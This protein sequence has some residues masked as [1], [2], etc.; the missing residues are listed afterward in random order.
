MEIVNIRDN[1]YKYRKIVSLFFVLITIILLFCMVKNI[2]RSGNLEVIY[3]D[4][5]QGD[6]ILIKD[7]RGLNFLID[8]GSGHITT[9]KVQKE[10]SVFNKALDSVLITHPDSD[11]SGGVVSVINSIDTERVIISTENDYSNYI[12]DKDSKVSFVNTF[13]NISLSNEISLK[14]LNPELGILGTENGKSIVNTMSYGNFNFIFTGDADSET[15]RKLVS[16]GYFDK[17]ENKTSV[18][19]LK[20][21]HHGS[22]TSSSEIFLKKIKPEYCILSVG[23]NNKYGHPAKNAMDRLEKYCKNIYRTDLNGGIS[24]K[25]DG[26]N[27]EISIEK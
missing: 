6:S 2:N 1:A 23:K 4:I 19:V 26:K 21:G 24:F 27:L 18:N 12:K 10:L 9:Q 8:T 25:T 22:D 15:E 16:Q 11:H 3:L 5:G 14:I 13:N 17:N 7:P 20:V